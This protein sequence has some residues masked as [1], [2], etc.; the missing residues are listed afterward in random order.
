[1]HTLLLLFI[2]NIFSHL[3]KQKG[4]NCH[5]F[6]YYRPGA[7]E[8]FCG[9]RTVS[10]FIDLI[11]MGI[12]AT[13]EN[14]RNLSIITAPRDLKHAR[15]YRKKKEMISQ[16]FFSYFCTY[17]FLQK[18]QSYCKFNCLLDYNDFSLECPART[19]LRRR[20]DS[21]WGCCSILYSTHEM[22]FATPKWNQSQDNILASDEPIRIIK[23]LRPGRSVREQSRP[24][25]ERQYADDFTNKCEINRIHLSAYWPC[26]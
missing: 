20:T 17:K 4:N 22:D 16:I 26:E 14:R 9:F 5:V 8:P 24:P 12:F 21:L 18:S 25:A 11:L 15:L 10:V 23:W 6:L 7:V 13:G 19:K 3:H 1:M 2:R